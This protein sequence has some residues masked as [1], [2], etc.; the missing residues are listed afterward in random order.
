MGWGSNQYG[1]RKPPDD[2]ADVVSVSCGFVHSAAITGDGR[3]VCWGSAGHHACVVPPT[4]ERAVA[5]SC[6]NGHT[7]ALTQNGTVVCWGINTSGECTVP[8]NTVGMASLAI[9]M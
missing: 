9:L 1:Q 5:V 7:A 4:L 3:V 8:R 2:L 6:G